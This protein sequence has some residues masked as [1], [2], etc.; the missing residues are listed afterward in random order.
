MSS[1]LCGDVFDVL[2]TLADDS[3]DHIITDP[4]YNISSKAK[5]TMVGPNIVTAE[6]GDWDCED[7]DSYDQMFQ[8]L[9]TE[10]CRIAKPGANALIWLDRA[11][12]GVGWFHAEKCGWTP[13]NIIAAVKRNPTPRLR[14]KNLK[15]A[16]EA[17]LWLSKGVV[18]SLTWDKS[19]KHDQNVIFYNIG[20]EKV[21]DH[22]TEKYES[23]IEP[24]V[25]MYTNEGDLVL[26]PFGGSGTT[27][28]VCKK[29]N[30][31]FVISEKNP[32]WIDVAIRRIDSTAK[33]LAILNEKREKGKPSGKTKS[34][35]KETRD[36]QHAEASN[37][38]AT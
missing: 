4:P 10:L 22:P 5:Q 13:R 34:S 3:V 30:R 7:K 38:T 9:I 24:L 15:S 1:I 27:A 19:Q 17:C 12:A 18:K 16:W 21:S 25:E 8:K 36:K 11:Y 33:P 28:V 26:D 14:T 32:R 37:T 31:D 6:F 35:G 2:A 23:M 20:S 29:K